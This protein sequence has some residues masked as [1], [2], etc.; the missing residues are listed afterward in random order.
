MFCNCQ[1]QQI[2]ELVKYMSRSVVTA[3]EQ[4]STAVNRDC[5]NGPVLEFRVIRP[6]CLH[7]QCRFHRSKRFLTWFVSNLIPKC[8]LDSSHVGTSNSRELPSLFWI[9]EQR[10]TCFIVFDS[11]LTLN[12]GPLTWCGCHLNDSLKCHIHC[13]SET[14]FQYN[15]LT[16]QLSCVVIF[17][18][19]LRELSS[20]GLLFEITSKQYQ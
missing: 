16:I 3:F 15:V 5:Q 9:R 1:W 11:V 20:E 4:H 17:W 8:G 12:I 7:E 6:F 10:K 13:T 19:I 2:I 14:V 18:L